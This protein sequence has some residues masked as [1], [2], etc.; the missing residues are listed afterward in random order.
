MRIKYPCTVCGRSVTKNHKALQ[1]G[2]CDQWVHTKCNLIDKKT[3]ELLKQDESPWS[4][5]KCTKNIFPFIQADPP[6]NNH[7][8]LT[9]KQQEII[10][11]LNQY[12]TSDE[13]RTLLYI[14]KS[15]NYIN[16]QDLN[17]YKTKELE[18]TFIEVILPKR[19]RNLVVGT[20]YRHPCM[21]ADEFNT[22]YLPKLLPNISK[23]IK[24]KDFVLMGDFNIDLLNYTSDNKVAE[25]LDKMYSSSLLPLI[26]HP[27]RISKTSQTLI[28]NIFSTI[29][30]DKSK[31]GN[32][33]TIISDHFCQFI[34]LPLA[35]NADNKK[36]QFGRNFRNF[37]KEHFS[38]DIKHV[39]W[40]NI[41]EIEKKI[42]I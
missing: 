10:N 22:Q 25:F 6:A 30:S 18:A 28:D 39:N 23:E 9:T 33:T 5:I 35:E 41:L 42:P 3:Y 16:R 20:I 19:K 4:C 15:L 7:N 34:S 29:I 37:D 31:T 27:T 8:H 12:Y 36:S 14:S 24:Q 11:A 21:D 32:I 1:C 2:Y 38:Q 40:E 17:L 26:T 13:L